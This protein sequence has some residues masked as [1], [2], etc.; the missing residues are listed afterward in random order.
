MSVYVEDGIDQTLPELLHVGST[1]DRGGRPK[2][3]A[4]PL[5]LVGR[6]RECLDRQL[7]GVPHPQQPLVPGCLEEVHHLQDQALWPYN[8]A[9]TGASRCAVT[10]WTQRW[11]A[12]GPSIQPLLMSKENHLSQKIIKLA[13]EDACRHTKQPAFYV[14]MLRNLHN[15]Q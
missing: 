10:T 8:Q 14:I 15:S 12:G 11:K 2:A 9:K 13:I 1:E 7:Q 6:Q 5:S 4:P 3:H